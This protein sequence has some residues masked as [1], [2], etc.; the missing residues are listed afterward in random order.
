MIDD[1]TLLALCGFQ[2]ANLEPDDGLAGVVRVVLN[3]ARL[4]YQSDGTVHGAVYWPDAFSWTQWEMDDGRY[5]KVAHT[6]AQVV[7]R[8]AALLAA[9]QGWHAAWARAGRIAAAVRAGTYRGPDYDRLG[10]AAVLYLNPAL[11][12]AAWATPDKRVCAIGRHE[13]FHA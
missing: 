6:G 7:A 11:S 2:E 3:R 9:A 13:F 5:V 10:D 12:R 4:K 8:S 1:P